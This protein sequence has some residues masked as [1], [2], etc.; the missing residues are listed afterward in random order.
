MAQ[1]LPDAKFGKLN[2]TDMAGAA[3]FTTE[4][5][6]KA[7]P[8]FHLYKNGAKVDQMTGNDPKGLRNLV[9]TALNK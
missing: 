2:L 4:R 5:A 3:A 6:V 9:V 8:T 7:L 1:D